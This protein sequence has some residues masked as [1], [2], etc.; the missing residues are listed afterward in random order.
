MS[1]TGQS[2]RCGRTASG[3]VTAGSTILIIRT[4]DTTSCVHPVNRT[5]AAAAELMAA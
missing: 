2:A 1:F 4:E 3:T 5:M